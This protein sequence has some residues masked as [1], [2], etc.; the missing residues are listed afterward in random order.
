MLMH[1]SSYK[2]PIRCGKKVTKKTLRS[3]KNNLTFVCKG[4]GRDSSILKY[5]KY[6]S[7]DILTFFRIFGKFRKVKMLW[8]LSKLRKFKSISKRNQEKIQRDVSTLEMSAFM[9]SEMCNRMMTRR[10]LDLSLSLV[11]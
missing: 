2:R 7:C 3:T 10:N 9:A 4:K 1:H 11:T 6:Y 5:S 8:S